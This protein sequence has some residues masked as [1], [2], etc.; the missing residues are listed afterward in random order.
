[1]VETEDDRASKYAEQVRALR[2]ELDTGIENAR[3]NGKRYRRWS[4]WLVL[5]TVIASFAG[6]ILAGIDSVPKV[7]LAIIT[8]LPGVLTLVSNN[9]KLEGRSVW[10]YKKRNALKA[11]RSRLLF[12]EG[13]RADVAA[14]AK[15]Q[16]A[17]R[18]Q[19]S[20]DWAEQLTLVATQAKQS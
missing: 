15:E 4:F 20:N 17:L 5:G 2:A 7:V 9:L 3:R 1:M 18:I 13:E 8:A 11:I 6:T 19:M 16:D 14:L 10:F 12:H